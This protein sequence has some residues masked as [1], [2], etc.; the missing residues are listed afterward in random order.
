MRVI[1]VHY[2]WD[3]DRERERNKETEG[4]PE[5]IEV[6]KQTQKSANMYIHIHTRTH[7]HTHTHTRIQAHEHVQHTHACAQVFVSSSN[8]RRTLYIALLPLFT[9]TRDMAHAV[10]SPNN[11]FH[12]RVLTR[13]LAHAN[14]HARMHARTHE[15]MCARTQQHGHN[16]D[17][18]DNTGCVCP[19]L[20]ACFPLVHW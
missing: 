8:H 1:V 6:F 4:Q 19:C 11:Q 10:K 20:T 17:L 5:C 13:T 18:I 3:T 2:V 15:N 14:T 7:M 9:V 12:A 16:Q